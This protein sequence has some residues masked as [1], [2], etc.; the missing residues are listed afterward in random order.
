VRDEAVGAKKRARWGTPSKLLVSK[1][2]E[3]GGGKKKEQPVS[4]GGK[5]WAKHKLTAKKGSGEK[6]KKR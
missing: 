3:K 2:T 5:G 1:K 6:R 4:G